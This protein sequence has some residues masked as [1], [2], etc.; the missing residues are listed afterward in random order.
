M[1]LTIHHLQVSQSERVPWLCEE[2]GIAYELVLHKR[3]P[4]F[5]PQSIKD[6]NPV[7]QAP[8]IQDDSLRLAESA[9]CIEYIIHKYGGGRLSLAPSHKD[10]AAYLYWFHFANGTFQPL[11]MVFMQVMRLDK[12]GQML[13]GYSDRF[14]NLLKIVDQR[15]GETHA[16]LAGEEFTAADIMIL[17]T[18]TTM[19]YFCGYDL[20]DYKG[21]L[22]Y[23]QRC[24]DREGYRNARAKA[25]PDLGFAIDAEAPRSFVESLK[26]QGKL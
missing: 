14:E 24:S 23:L 16:Y 19:R 3:A 11:L 20:T 1:V 10:Y 15:L 7:G 8:V 13:K 21:I 4:I 26:E 5:S 9:A 18:L 6:L 25:D 12:D 22:E 17:F 2:L